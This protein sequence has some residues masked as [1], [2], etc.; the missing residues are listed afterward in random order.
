MPSR[1]PRDAPRVGPGLKMRLK[2]EFWIKAYLRHCA[3]QFAPAVVVR[4]GQGDAGA[5]YIKVNR[6]DGT[7][8]IYGPGPPSLDR[9]PDERVWTLCLAADPV[10]ES[11]ADAYLRRQVQ[12]DSDIWIVEVEDPAGRHFLGDAVVGT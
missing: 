1:L 4:R 11:A 7:C 6:L 12:Y 8:T 2:T 5:I 3:G 9:D 10:S